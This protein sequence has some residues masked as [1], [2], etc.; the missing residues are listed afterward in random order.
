MFGEVELMLLQY[1][2]NGPRFANGDVFGF[3][4][5]PRV[6]L[7]Y[8]GNDGLGARVRWWD[9]SHANNDVGNDRHYVDTYNVDLELSKAIDV[10]CKTTV[11]VFAGLRY[12]DFEEIHFTGG[13]YDR[14]AFSGW[15]GLIGLQVDHDCLGGTVYARMRT[16]VLMGDASDDDLGT[17][18]DS[19]REQSEIAFGYEIERCLANGAVLTLRAGTEM[20]YWPEYIIDGVTDD[21]AGIGF[22]GFVLGLALNY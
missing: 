5:S 6:T 9:Y 10:T 14:A 22:G 16:A 7:G 11:E 3:E 21:T 1:H 20:Q 12:N 19:V 15:G 18:F 17:Y 8:A 4:F 13:I 2:R